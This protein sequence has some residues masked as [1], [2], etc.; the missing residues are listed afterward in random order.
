[1]LSGD[2]H[3]AYAATVLYDESVHSSVYQLTCSPVH[4]YVPTVM[5]LAFRLSWS[6]VAEKVT[7]VLL[8]GVSRVPAPEVEWARLCGP[9]FGDQLATLTL[10]GRSAVLL[11]ERA[12]LD[13]AGRAELAPAAT[14]RLA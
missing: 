8:S 13:P 12:G 14:L 4:N 2:V 6:R 9:L 5:K 10:D 11:I 3:H 7:R 1:V